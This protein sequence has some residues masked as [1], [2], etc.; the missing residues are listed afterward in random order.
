MRKPVKKKKPIE[1]E[2]PVSAPAS[3]HKRLAGVTGELSMAVVRRSITK[4]QIQTWALA[5]K[6]VGEEMNAFANRPR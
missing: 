1:D 4:A 5:L 2:V 3:W 6:E